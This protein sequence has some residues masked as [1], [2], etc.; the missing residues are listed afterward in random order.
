MRLLSG[1]VY[2]SHHMYIVT[3][4]FHFLDELVMGRRDSN[5]ARVTHKEGL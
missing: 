5:P 1:L 2:D 4:T 3:I